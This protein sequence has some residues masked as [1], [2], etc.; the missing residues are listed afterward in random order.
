MEVG[1][2]T[3]VIDDSLIYSWLFEC[4]DCSPVGGDDVVDNERRDLLWEVT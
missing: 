1:L 4:W 3:C 2:G